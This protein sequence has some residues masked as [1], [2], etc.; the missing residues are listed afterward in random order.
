MEKILEKEMNAQINRELFSAYLYL[1]MVAYLEAENLNGFAHWMRIQ[2]LEEMTHAMKFFN[3]LSE[4]GATIVLEALEKP[5][6][7]IT[8]VKDVFEKALAHEKYITKSINDLYAMAKKENDNAVL[9]FLEWFVTEQVEEEKNASEILGKLKYTG[10]RGEGI[11]MIDKELSLR[12]M[13]AL[14]PAGT[15]APAA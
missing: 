14:T 12:P 4:R 15:P 11:L 2:A 7:K 6:A 10:E 1:A 13:P 3:H 9:I 8:S 5:S